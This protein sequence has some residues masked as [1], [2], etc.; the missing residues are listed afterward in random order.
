[1]NSNSRTIFNRIVLGLLSLLFAVFVLVVTAY[2]TGLTTGEEFSPDDFSRRR[3]FYIRPSWLPITL[4]GIRYESTTDPVSRLLLV[5]RHLVPLQTPQKHWDLVQ[6]N[7]MPSDSVAYDA[8]ILCRYLDLVDSD[9]LHIFERWTMEHPEHAAV[10]WPEVA[11]V[12]RAGRYRDVSLL[13]E[14]VVNRSDRS[15]EEFTIQLTDVM[16]LLVLPD[17]DE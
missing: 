5:D 2:A 13:M 8:R 16:T 6:D 10:F 4:S 12:A 7:R 9:G 15:L 3:F 14:L 1:M 11:R 17:D